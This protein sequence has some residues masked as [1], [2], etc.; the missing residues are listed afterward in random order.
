MPTSVTMTYGPYSFVPVPLVSLNYNP[1]KTGDQ[2]HLSPSISLTLN[3][4]LTSLPTG[5]GGIISIDSLQDTLTSGL[6]TDGLRF[7]IDC[8]GAIILEAYPRI[9]SHSFSESV[10]N[11]VFTSPYTIEM[12]YDEISPTISGTGENFVVSAQDSWN[13]QFDESK[14]YFNVDLNTAVP[15]VK[16]YAGLDYVTDASPYVATI[17]HDISAQGVHHYASGYNQEGWKNAQTYVI[18][19]LGIDNTHVVGSGVINLTSGNPYNHMRTRVVDELGGTFSVSESWLIIDSGNAQIYPGL[20]TEDFTANIR[21]SL[22][23]DITSVNVEGTIIGLESRNY[24]DGTADRFT[25]SSN[26]YDN[27]VAYWSGIQ[28]RILPRAQSAVEGVANR[29]LNIF[30]STQSIGHAPSQGSITYNYDYDDRP[31]NCITGALSENI[32][33]T[34]NNPTDVFASLTILGRQ[35]GPILQSIDTFTQRTRTLNVEVVMPPSTGCTYVFLYGS[36]STNPREDVKDN[37]VCP[38]EQEITNSQSQVFVSADT[39]NWNPKGRYSRNMTWTFADCNG[40]VPSGACGS[41]TN[42]DVI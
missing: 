34:D 21:K 8:G 18:D 17:T 35:A 22:E 30:A 5:A 28:D 1:I 11:W 20:A 9:T 39:E 40:V 33:I 29:N 15:V 42:M 3:G 10:D 31:S 7:L 37:I 19:R 12:E 13:F 27:A 2:T 41:G 4:T 36:G 14:S 32:S 23:S 38:M 24:N 16:Q 25:I 26:K 6:A